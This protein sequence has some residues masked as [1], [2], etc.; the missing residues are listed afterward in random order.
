MKQL[1]TINIFL[2]GLI[3]SNTL[4]AVNM[5][6]LNNSPV[7]IF[8]KEDTQLMENTLYQALD[9]LKD[10]EKLAWHNPDSNNRGSIFIEKTFNKQLQIC[11]QVQIINQ[12]KNQSGN[13]RFSFC[14]DKENNWKL[15]E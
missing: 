9:N 15:V 5:K 7:S 14:K 8:S 12:A 3:L 1:M 4:F 2:L 10:G 13:S 6:F 11:R